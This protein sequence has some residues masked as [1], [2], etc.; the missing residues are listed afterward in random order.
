MPG[1]V[2]AAVSNHPGYFGDLMATAAE[3]SGAA[4]PEG[5]DSLS[6][7]PVLTG[8]GTPRRHPYLYWEFHEGGSSQAVLLEGRWKGLRLKR[9]DAPLVVYDLRTDPG[10]AT[11]VA[12]ARPDIVERLEKILKEAHTGNPDWPLVDAPQAE[13]APV[14]QKAGF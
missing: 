13:P 2:R 3:L 8:K 12:S 7:M 5:R 6:L 14:P 9:R 11:D 1:T 10:E 4:L